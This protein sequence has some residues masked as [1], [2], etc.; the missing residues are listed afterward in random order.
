MSYR[1]L[2]GDPDLG[3]SGVMI[4]ADLFTVYDGQGR[5][6]VATTDRAYA[7]ALVEA[8][9]HMGAYCLNRKCETVFGTHPDRKG[10]KR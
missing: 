1:L 5:E 9:T 7:K 2:D 4:S 8:N 6:R 3:L 10:E